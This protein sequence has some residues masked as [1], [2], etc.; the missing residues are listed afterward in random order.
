L[1][2]LR[3]GVLLAL[4][5]AVPSDRVSINEIGLTPA[6]MHSVRRGRC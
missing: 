6:D 4:D 2:D 3:E 1:P 5:R